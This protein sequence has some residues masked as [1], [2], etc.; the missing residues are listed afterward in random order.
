MKND[1]IVRFKNLYLDF[2]IQQ[3]DLS[4]SDCLEFE[5]ENKEFWGIIRS[6]KIIF[7]DNIYNVTLIIEKENQN[8]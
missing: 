7:G 3:G 1:E 6:G 8:E 2:I 5:G 4:Y